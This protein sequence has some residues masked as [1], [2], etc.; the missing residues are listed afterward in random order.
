MV[1]S[2]YK[3]FHIV[4]TDEKTE[5]GKLFPYDIY[6]ESKLIKFSEITGPVWYKIGTAKDLTEAKQKVDNQIKKNEEKPNRWD[7]F[8]NKL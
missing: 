2:E 3:G 7:R 1:I 4:K 6:E 8:F 5:Y